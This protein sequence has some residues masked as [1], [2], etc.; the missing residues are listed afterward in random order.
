MKA[1][2]SISPADFA[3]AKEFARRLA[4]QIDP[5]LFTVTLIGAR[6]KGRFRKVFR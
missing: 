4:E 5:Q 1:P 2:T 3:L 6:G